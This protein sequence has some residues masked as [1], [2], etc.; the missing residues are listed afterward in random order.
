M[1]KGNPTPVGPLP[2]HRTVGDVM[3]SSVHVA[4]PLTPFKHLVQMIE[5]NRISAI[6][7]IDG[8]GMPIGVVS[9]ADLLLKE[10]RG[11]L[12]LDASPL[13]LWR[14]RLDRAKADGVIASDLMTSPPITVPIA[15][16]IADAARIMHQRNV[17]RLVVVDD[18]GRI[19]GIVSRSDLLQVFLR[20]DEDI[21]DD[22]LNGI[23]HTVVPLD[24]AALE[25]DVRANV[26]S[27]S[28]EVDRWS[29]SVIIE[30]LSR[31]VDGVVD[32]VNKLTAR[33][34]DRKGQAQIN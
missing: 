33:W 2:R 21:R 3:T 19:A 23:A 28:G 7:I 14:R 22:V 30:R 31:E 16:P 15:T 29:D 9:E 17:R 25:V 18:R 6:P 32:V 27:L 8:R 13:H 4:G 11:E 1:E 20:S 10:R 26:V 34:D 5:D 12:E 24:A